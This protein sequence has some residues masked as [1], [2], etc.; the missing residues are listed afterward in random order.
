MDQTKSADKR[1]S[2]TL[3]AFIG[4]APPS[5]EVKPAVFPKSKLKGPRVRCIAVNP[6]SLKPKSFDACN[7]DSVD[8]VF[9]ILTK[10]MGEVSNSFLFLVF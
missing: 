7:V 8:K 3:D 4:L 9:R 10:H 6:S 5:V 1:S 2:A